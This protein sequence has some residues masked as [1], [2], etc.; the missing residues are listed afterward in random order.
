MKTIGYI[1]FALSCGLWCVI[2]A[3]PFVLQ[4]V[5]NIVGINTVLFVL[6]E[7][8]FALSIFILGKAFWQKFKS[9]FTKYFHKLFKK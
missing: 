7:G 4:N 6:S 1:L 9:F 2:F 3:L 8:C 5:K